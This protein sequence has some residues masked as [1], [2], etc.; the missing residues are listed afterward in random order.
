MAITVIAALGAVL[1]MTIYTAI[2]GLLKGIAMAKK[3]GFV[4]VV[5]PVSPFNRI[6]QLTSW[7]TIPLIK[8]LPKPLWENWLFIL[9]PSWAYNTKQEHWKRLGTETFVIVSP[10][11]IILFTQHPQLINQLTQRRESFPKDIAL[12]GVLDM[13]GRNVLTTEGTLWRLHRKVTS[14][15]FNEKN[16]AH[17]FSEAIKQ[18]QG[19]LDLWFDGANNMSKTI[20]TLEHDTMRW[21]L[22]IIGY[23]GFGLRLLWPGQTMPDDVDPKLAKYGSLEPPA[24]H[25][26]SFVDSVELV[27]KHIVAILLFPTALLGLLPFKF[28]KEGY[29]AK[30]NF[31]KYMDEF[32]H[33]K[34]EEAKRGGEPKE[35]MDIMGQLVQSR[36]NDKSGTEAASGF[37]LSDAEIIGNAFIM[38]VAG[39]ETTANTLHFAL[40]ELATNPASQRRLQ[41]DIDSLF[42]TSDPSTWDYDRSIGPLLASHVGACIN[43]TLRLLPPVVTIPKVVNHDTDQTA[44][45]DGRTHVMPAGMKCTIITV[46]TQRNPRWWP[47]GPSE[48]TGQDN[49][50]DEFLPERWYRTRGDSSNGE[51]DGNDGGAVEDYGGFQGSDVS[52]ALYR[53]VRGSYVPFSDGP[54][55]CLGRRIAMVELAAA[56]AA[57]FQKYSIELAVEEWASDEQVEAM[58]PEQ[59]REVYVKAQEKSRATI[60]KADY[61]ALTLKLHNGLYVPVR[62]VKRGHER[63]VSD[64]LLQ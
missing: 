8:L 36:H 9:L 39:H 30:V 37:R 56:L 22:N 19:I 27:L 48:R 40:I 32:L 10:G 28:A 51:K 14:A 55:S 3:T 43:E 21:A 42:G 57:I 26:L 61:S 53:P 64:P 50:L 31:L 62:L 49:D 11:D 60:A 1:A 33:D 46:C 44:T 35:G 29:H 12:Y 41:R 38:I 54:R 24:G 34:M 58:T 18:T 7:L 25:T 23:V 52:A 59:R 6:W 63:F 16:A 20:K 15:S 45:V 17:T 13:F 2:S 5:S 4:Y 47:T